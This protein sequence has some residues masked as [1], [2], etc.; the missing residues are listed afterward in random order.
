[1]AGDQ[2]QVVA[3][4]N[5]IVYTAPWQPS[6]GI[7]AD[8]IAWGT[9]W[10]APY[11]DKGYTREGLRFRLQ[12]QRQNVQ[13][14]QVVDPVL[15]IPQSRDL[16]M[17]T[18]LAQINAFNFRDATGQGSTTSVAP[19]AAVAAPSAAPTLATATTGGSLG[20][21]IYIVGYTWGTANGESVLGPT[22]QIT[23]PVGNSTNTI[24]VTIPAFPTNATFAGVY[25]S[26]SPG[27]TN[28]L[29]SGQFST[30]T[31]GGNLVV[32]TYPSGQSPP[33]VGGTSAVGHD[34]YDI[35][36]TIIDQYITS[37]FD[38]QNPGDLQAMRLI[39][40]KGIILA[41]VELQFNVTD[42]AQLQFTAGLVPDTSSSPARVAKFRDIQSTG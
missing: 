8:T 26:S 7:P 25:V 37:G 10:G 3:G 41:Q 20:P 29:K 5:I 40:W 19:G 15:R 14:D 31:T 2:T 9:A 24:T 42:A 21:G 30:P 36:G 27:S 13:V 6:N 28:L 18:R 38:V 17:E 34:D 4:R 16:S 32:T 1:M 35:S 11:L 33:A 39:G 12:V 23:V 22:A